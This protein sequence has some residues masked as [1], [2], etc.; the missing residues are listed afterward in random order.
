MRKLG[1]DYDE[2]KKINPGII[3]CSIC[4]FGHDALPEYASK[5]AY[6]MVAQAY[7]G[8]MSITGPYKCPPVRVGTSMGDIVAG[9]QAAIGI[10]T[11][12]YHRQKTGLGQ[13]VDISMVDGL[14]YTLENAVVRYTIDG[15]VPFPLGSMHPTI[16]PFQG[17]E[18][19]DGKFVITPMGNDNL[20]A[21]FCKVLGREDLIK[22]EL[23]KTNKLRTQNRP[24][25][26]EILEAEM[27][28]RTAQEWLDA[29]EA[30]GL[31]NSPINTI[32]QVV[33]DPNI[34]HRKMIV[35]MEQPKVGPVTTAGSPFHL[36]ETPGEVRTPAPLLGQ[37]T[38]EVLKDWLGYDEAKIDKLLKE[39]VVISADN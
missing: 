18:A 24:A 6:D 16:T 35:T 2:L 15:E 19:K 5:P 29:L 23:F 9:H 11:A 30:A 39:G 33:K 37:H 21:G 22:N 8:L 36:S 28:K 7:S 26:L 14:V 1:M 12:L 27:K 38:K 34:N 17:F 31:P 3:Y 13:H 10:L 20:F 4:G 25:L 32:D